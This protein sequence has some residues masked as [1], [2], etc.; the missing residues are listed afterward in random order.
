MLVSAAGAAP[1]AYITN[2]DN[3]VSVIDTA[4]NN[5]T[6]TALGRGLSPV[7]IAVSPDGTKVYL[8]EHVLEGVVYA[9]D[10]TTNLAVPVKVGSGPWGVAVSPDSTKVYVTNRGDD[11]VSVIDTATNNVTDTVSVGSSPFEVAV[12]PDGKYVYVT[13]Y[14]SGT[15]DVIDTATNKVTATVDVEVNPTGVAV[16][17]DGKKVYVASEGANS[18]FVID[19]ATNEV[20]ATVKVGR[21]PVAF[22]QFIGG[23]Q[24]TLV[25]A[26]SACP[27]SGKT[28]LAVKFTDESAGSP[29]SWLWDF[30]DCSTSTVKD[31][32]HNYC[33]AGRYTVSLTVENAAGNNSV[34]KFK[35]ITVKNK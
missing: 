29:T 33:K 18:V 30:G 21:L 22:G 4:T 5:I 20:T 23:K 17:L 11:T 7:G 32:V 19:T 31:P 34:T 28:P 12:T 9:L 25:A 16:T 26:F 15:V 27:E 2:L 14:N 6:A 8:T 24:D 13:N 10:T 1:F 35:Y 3:T